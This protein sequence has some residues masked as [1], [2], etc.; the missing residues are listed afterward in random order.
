MGAGCVL[1]ILSAWDSYIQTLF[2]PLGALGETVVDHID[3]PL[4]P[5][6]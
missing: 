4:A 2:F 5:I 6:F 1:I 3:Q